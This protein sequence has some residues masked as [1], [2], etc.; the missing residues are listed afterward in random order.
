MIP[1]S[2]LI[3]GGD[4]WWFFGPRV[5]P[6]D[7]L[8]CHRMPYDY[9]VTDTELRRSHLLP[10]RRHALHQ[11]EGRAG[12]AAAVDGD[13]LP[14]A[15]GQGEEAV[16]RAE[17]AG[18]D[19]RAAR[20]AR[21]A[22]SSQFID[23]IQS[24]RA[25]TSGCFDRRAGRRPAGRQRARAAQPGQ[26]HHRVAGL[27]DDH[28]GRDRQGPHHRA[29]R[30]ARL[31]EGDGRASR[32]TAAWS[33]STPSSPTAPTTGR[34]AATCSRGGPSTSACPAATATARRWA[35]GCSTTWRR[36]PAS[37]ATIT[38]SSAQYRNPAFT[39]D[40]TFLSGRGRRHAGRAQAQAPRHGEGG[41][42]QP[43]R[44]RD[45]QGHRRRRAAGRMTRPTRGRPAIGPI[46]TS[47]RSLG[48]ASPNRGAPRS[49][50][51]GRGRARRA[52]RPAI[53]AAG[54]AARRWPPVA[55]PAGGT[56]RRRRGRRSPTRGR[57]SRPPARG[58]GCTRRPTRPGS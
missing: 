38:H 54:A 55:A 17:G 44:R 50:P 6:G 25:T 45:G 22:A 14:G 37:G 15:R 49:R 4:D 19:R 31:H 35:R 3:F 33:A 46:P 10:A 57:P 7:K 40:A 24:A 48:D 2:H 51:S 53:S 8:V 27:P 16:L 43:G 18:V 21:G 42:A 56:I 58:R 41:A 34:P 23:Q 32:A 12:R 30:G 1:N 13:P 9:K 52:P 39:G 36:G 26:L 47:T 11:P 5:W 28:L 29:G 20:R